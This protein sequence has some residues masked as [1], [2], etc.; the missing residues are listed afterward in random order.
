MALSRE[1]G[2]LSRELWHGCV[3]EFGRDGALALI[4]YVGLY[5]YTCVLLNGCDVALPEGETIMS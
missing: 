2:P 1:P 3:N 4:H 5:A